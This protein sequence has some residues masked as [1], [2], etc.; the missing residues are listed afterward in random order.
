M[1]GMK[2]TYTV[3]SMNGTPW[4]NC[5]DGLKVSYECVADGTGTKVNWTWEGDFVGPEV[6]NMKKPG[7]VRGCMVA[8]AD[9]S[10][11]VHSTFWVWPCARA[12]PHPVL[13]S[14]SS[15]VTD[16]REIFLM[17]ATPAPRVAA[18]AD[19]AVISQPSTRR[20]RPVYASPDL[21]CPRFVLPPLRHCADFVPLRSVVRGVREVGP[22]EDHQVHGQGGG[23]GRDDVR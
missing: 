18:L 16:A 5:K 14:R 23:H 9:R 15:E 10:P 3:T 20:A 8:T 21:S 17:P 4:R 19:L 13:N 1:D 12:G 6:T 11:V 7:K 22:R 2:L